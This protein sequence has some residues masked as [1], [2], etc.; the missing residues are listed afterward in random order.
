[1]KKQL[2]DL[3]SEAIRFVR[4]SFS[5][6]EHTPLQVYS[7]ALAFVARCSLVKS[8]FSDCIPPW[9]SLCPKVS[10]RWDACL[11]VL[12]GHTGPVSCVAFSRNSKLLA[13]GARDGTIRIWE[14]ATDDCKTVLYDGEINGVRSLDFSHDSKILAATS[15]SSILLW[16]VQTGQC[17]SRIEHSKLDYIRTIRF[18]LDSKMLLSGS[19]DGNVRLWDTRSGTCRILEGHQHRI[20]SVRFSPDNKRVL[21]GSYD[22][23]SR[24]WDTASGECLF[25]LEGHR[26]RVN[27]VAFS[28]DANTLVTASCDSTI[29]CWDANTGSCQKVLYG[30][31]S[32]ITSVI[33]LGSLKNVLASASA[34][35][36]MILWDVDLG[37]PLSAIKAHGDLI[38]TVACDSDERMVASCSDDGTIRIWAIAGLFSQLP[39]PGH[40]SPVTSLAFSRNWGVLASSSEDMTVRIW[41]ARTGKPQASLQGHGQAVLWAAFSRDST[42]LVTTARD[43]TSRI[44]DTLSWTCVEEI[45]MSAGIDVV[46]FSP[47]LST[48]ASTHFEDTETVRLWDVATD[49]HKAALQCG[50]CHWIS[51][52]AYSCDSSLLAVGVGDDTILVWDA[53]TESCLHVLEGHQEAVVTM[54]FSPSVARATLFAS[55]SIDTTIRTWDASTG[56]CHAVLQ[57]HTESITS[58]A[59]SSDSRRLASGSRDLTV[60]IWDTDATSCLAIMRTSSVAYEMSFSPDNRDIITSQG[61]YSLPSLDD[62]ATTSPVELSSREKGIGFSGDSWLTLDGKPWLWLPAQCRGGIKRVEG[63]RVAIGC[64]SGEVII[65]GIR[66][67]LASA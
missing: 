36:S 3:V 7:S 10:F 55:G 56:V 33:F 21:S 11:A 42:R 47:D 22:K 6:I 15:S 24:L 65:L 8:L 26:A 13:S 32:E 34:N 27:S 23:T 63:D 48:M 17:T 19:D 37:G 30:Q 18:S 9:L 53:E 28:R 14:T 50:G 16:D 41:N 45:T 25:V 38:Q 59:F 62:S 20:E 5:A 1:L 44:W 43:G 31:R 57:G 4:S 35:G 49:Q 52:M 61:S 66:S 60:R 67:D 58:L 12:E 54:A 46:L 39:L 64:R 29:R 40:S 51:A 2:T